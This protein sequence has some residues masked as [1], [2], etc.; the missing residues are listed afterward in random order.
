MASAD[1]AARVLRRGDA[2]GGGRSRGTSRTSPRGPAPRA[3][4]E[5][6]LREPSPADVIAL[7]RLARV[8]APGA[9]VVAGAAIPR[10]AIADI[11]AGF[12]RARGGAIRASRSSGEAYARGAKRRVRYRQTANWSSHRIQTPATKTQTP[13][14]RERVEC[15]PRA[16]DGATSPMP[17]SSISSVVFRRAADRR[18]VTAARASTAA[19]AASTT[20]TS[21][22][23]RPIRRRRASKAMV[24]RRGM[25]RDLDERPPWRLDLSADV[26][27]LGMEEHDALNPERGG[28]G[29]A[30]GGHASSRQ[31]H[32]VDERDDVGVSVEATVAPVGQG[33]FIEGNVRMR[34][35]VECEC[36][37]VAHVGEAVEA[38]MRIWL[39]AAASEPDASGEWDIVP[40]PRNAEECDLSGAVRDYVR[41]AAPYETLCAACGDGDGEADEPFTFRLEPED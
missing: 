11:V 32:D 28:R 31:E 4:R 25:F 8:A 5:R 3:T 6:R 14:R 24:F 13:T 38:P 1:A 9:R 23:A 21:T 16:A 37:G 30:T 10:R 26:H 33:F 19:H 7:T 17:T 27:E 29:G 15:S 12:R 20:K 18:D 2:S 39:D 35:V 41:L 34:C 36:C 22:P 40:F